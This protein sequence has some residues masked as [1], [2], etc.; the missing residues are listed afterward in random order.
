MQEKMFIVR[1]SCLTEA[2]RTGTMEIVS[3]QAISIDARKGLWVSAI[4]SD[5]ISAKFKLQNP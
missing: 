2:N 4:F 3:I 5:K 1:D